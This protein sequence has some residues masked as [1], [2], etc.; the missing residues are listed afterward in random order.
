[1]EQILQLRD[2]F[3][4]GDLSVRGDGAVLLGVTA[5]VVGVKAT[6]AGVGAGV[7]IAC[8]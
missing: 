5:C 7:A 1:M 8:D 6:G 4:L 2:G 3:P